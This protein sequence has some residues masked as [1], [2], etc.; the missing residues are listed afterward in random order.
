M[1]NINEKCID[2]KLK[3]YYAPQFDNNV[4][5]AEADGNE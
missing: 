5:L 4:G 1:G 3:A 2:K